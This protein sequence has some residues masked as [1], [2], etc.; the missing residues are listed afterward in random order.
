MV[1]AGEACHGEC[2][3]GMTQELNRFWRLPGHS[4]CNLG[5]G[6]PIKTNLFSPVRMVVIVCLEQA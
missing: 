1:K 2:F 6:Q 4:L 3:M 5:G